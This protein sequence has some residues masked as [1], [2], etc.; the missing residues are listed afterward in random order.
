MSDETNSSATVVATSDKA[1]DYKPYKFSFKTQ[2]LKDEQGN[3]ISKSKRPTL[4]F[5]HFPVP[6]VE[7]LEIAAAAGGKQL[8]LI[9]EAMETI[10]LNRAREIINENEAI[11]PDNFPYNLVTWEAIANQPDSE[12]RGRGIPKEQWE[13]FAKDYIAVMPGVTGKTEKQIAAAAEILLDKFNK[14]RS[15]RDFK[16]ILRLLLDQIALYLSNSPNAETYMDCV[17]FLTDKGERL[18]NAEEVSLLEVL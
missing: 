2:V 11:S 14:L 3:E 6:S 4:E 15:N 16:K 8:Q 1:V 5:T 13:E 9:L 18:L 10:V 12:R 7:G 17:S